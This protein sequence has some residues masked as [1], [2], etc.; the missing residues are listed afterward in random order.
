LSGNGYAEYTIPSLTQH[1]IFGLSYGNTGGGYTEIDF[2]IYA[3]ANGPT[4]HVYENGSFIGSH[5]AYIVGDV[6]R[7]A[8][9]GGVVKY[10]KNGTLLYTSLVSPT[11]PLLV[12]TSMSDENAYIEG[13]VIG[14]PWATP[15][16]A[17][18]G[19][20]YSTIAVAVA[21]ITLS[22]AQ[23]IDGQSVIAG[24]QVLVSAQST[25]GDNGVYICAAGAWTKVT[26]FAATTAAVII[27]QK[28]TL[29][30]ETIWLVSA[31]NTVKASGGVW[32]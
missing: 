23:T 16:P 26:G 13:A 9:E 30:A 14:G 11:Y 7:I 20:V 1:V 10:R 18:A 3:D 24:D 21:N 29:Y 6:L 25:A 4:L 19:A 8:V 2:A 15:G 5:G 31:L 27:V 22:G 32:K 28:G 17:G 12:D